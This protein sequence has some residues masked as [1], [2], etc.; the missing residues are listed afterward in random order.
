L[1]ITT[2]EIFPVHPRIPRWPQIGLQWF[3]VGKSSIHY[4]F[5][6]RWRST[7]SPFLFAKV[8]SFYF[9]QRFF[10]RPTCLLP[11]QGTVYFQ[12]DLSNRNE[13]VLP[14]GCCQGLVEW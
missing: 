11:F 13:G 10:R 4:D 2:T 9:I 6:I 14:P 3:G 7:H 1:S 12:P 5:E 8:S